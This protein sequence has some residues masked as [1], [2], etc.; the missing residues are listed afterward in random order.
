MINSLAQAAN[1]MNGVLCGEDQY[2][3][4]VSTD[5]RTIQDGEIFFA[6]QGPNFDGHEYA[7]S[8]K[9]NGAVAAVVSNEA[10]DQITK[11]R[12]DDTRLALARFGAAWRN[13]QDVCVVGI[14]GSN[15]K[16]TLKELVAA[17]LSTK[18]PTLATHG[19]LNNE[20]GIPLMLAR[21]HA[22]HEYAVIEMGANHTGEI[23]YL[24][25]L[26][27]PDV[28]VITNAAASHLE[29]FG[30]VEGVAHAKGEILQTR[31]RPNFAVLNADDE[32]YD[33]WMSLVDDVKT[34][35]FGLTVSADITADNIELGTAVSTFDLHLPNT[36]INISL[37]L[38]GIHNV[39][40]ACAAAAVAFALG[41]D[42]EQIKFALG[43]IRP[44][45]G[46]LQPLL[47]ING[48]TLFD[49]SYN[50]NPLSTKA[51][52]KFL[53]SLK[54]ESWFVLGDMKELGDDARDLHY[55]V[56]TSLRACG[57]DRLF[58]HGDLAKASVKAF[59]QGANWYS[60]IN[61]L[62]EDARTVG[63]ATNVL[64]KGS[65]LMQMER[66]VN[67]LQIASSE[68]KEA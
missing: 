59:G 53:A 44:I 29:G 47:G 15:G 40:N 60:D 48:C 7:E 1:F 39:Q 62:I 57:I 16:T 55:E 41:V 12:V 14:T 65:R 3:S 34:L 20:I 63:S 49:D 54:G 67:A 25:S 31:K 56:G 36:S 33:Y 10:V 18:A 32:Y 5:T 58:A 22:E 45:A 28:V 26:V 64:V 23:A 17:C 6:L 2:F 30:S 19:N 4:G 13:S 52:A 11:I 68:R 66:V 38:S 61:K 37:P 35:S 42:A 24:S 21:I 51:A 8:A 50:A 9:L 27:N 43:A 46:R